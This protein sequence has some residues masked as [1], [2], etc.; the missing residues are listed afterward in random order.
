MGTKY[1]CLIVDDEKPAHQVL[2]SHINQ[3]EDLECVG[4]AFSGKE[5]LLFL[6]KNEVDILLLDI[7]MPLISGLEFLDMLAVKP[8]TII[9]TA[10]SDFA[11]ESYEKDAVD[12]LLK[13]ISFGKFLKAIEKAKIFCKDRRESTDVV[14]DNVLKIRE[15]GMDILLDMDEIL[16][17]ESAGNYIKIYVENRS[18][19]YFVYGSLI[20]IKT[21]LPDYF[22]QVHRS[23]I[24]N[25]K[26][27]VK[28]EL[29]KVTLLAAIEVPVGR[30]YQILI[31]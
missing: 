22:I 2:T 27:I 1:K 11:L 5:A 28:K 30:K 21:E 9:T 25:R 18:K 23:F 15:D 19:S 17:I 24:V 20:S 7:N 31:E 13:P 14:K 3:C 12:Y 16:F 8:I 4:N 26:H 6:Q 29:G 10:Y